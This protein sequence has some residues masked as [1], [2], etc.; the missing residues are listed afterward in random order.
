M[1]WIFLLSILISSAWAKEYDVQMKSISF[2]PKM[3]QIALGDSVKWSNISLT[4]HSATG[5]KFD[6]GMIRPKNHSKAIV[7]SQA[8]SYSYNCQ[9]HGKT[10]SGIVQVGNK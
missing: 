3:I 7:F 9:V 1:K 2:E 8:G 10:M 4:E 5:E 6:T